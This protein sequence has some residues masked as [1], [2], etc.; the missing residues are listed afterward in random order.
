VSGTRSGTARRTE[1]AETTERGALCGVLSAR[2]G[3]LLAPGLL[4]GAAGVDRRSAD[5]RISGRPPQVC[6]AALSGSLLPSAPASACIT[7]SA[8]KKSCTHYDLTTLGRQV[9]SIFG[10]P[11]PGT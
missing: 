5:R 2:L 11:C 1:Q 3:L 8:A 9:P 10:Q 6:T 7:V 4:T